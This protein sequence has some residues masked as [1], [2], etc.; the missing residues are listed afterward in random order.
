[1]CHT[2]RIKIFKIL[3]L[4]SSIISFINCVPQETTTVKPGRYVPELYGAHLGKYIPDDSGKYFH[5]HRPYDGGYGDRGIKYVHDASGNLVPLSTRPLGPKDH[6]RF[7]IDFNYDNSGWQIINFEWLRDG[8][9][10]Y[11]YKF[12]NENQ[13]FNGNGDTGEEASEPNN[14]E[15][16]VH[17]DGE[18]NENNGYNYSYN[19]GGSNKNSKNLQQAIREVIFYIENNI[20]PTL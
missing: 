9:E 17:I 7:M 19:N 20:L 8:D 3:I 15:S 13:L 11:K 2:E 12:V 10:N 1:M 18:Y 16:D 6:L 4:W 14:N 5:I